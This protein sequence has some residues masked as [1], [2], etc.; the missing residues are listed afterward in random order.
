M[1]CHRTF[2][3]VT[4]RVPSQSRNCWPFRRTYVHPSF[5]LRGSCFSICSLLCGVLLIIVFPFLFS[6]VLYVLQV[7]KEQVCL[8]LSFLCGLI[9]NGFI[10]IF[11]GRYVPWGVIMLLQSQQNSFASSYRKHLSSRSWLAIQKIIFYVKG[12]GH[13][14]MNF[15]IVT[16]S[17][18]TV[19]TLV[20]V[21]AG[22]HYVFV[23]GKINSS[24]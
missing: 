1:T 7:T 20:G 22:L 8:R 3:K 16:F 4:R 11:Q 10:G 15:H 5:F 2:N 18:K 23:F 12:K 24:R 19:M 13:P 14:P 17:R 21:D 6:I 9:N